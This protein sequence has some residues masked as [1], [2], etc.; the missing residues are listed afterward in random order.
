MKTILNENPFIMY[1]E[2]IATPEECQSI[3]NLAQKSIQPAQ[4]YGHTGERTS[5][6]TWLAHHS[7]SIVH[8][9]SE[10]ISNLIA[11]PLP[12][13]EPLQVASYPVGGKFSAHLD[14]Y[15]THTEYGK[16]K[17]Q[18][19]GQRH[20]TAI[21]YL[22]TVTSGGET[23]FPSL[24]VTISP[25]QGNLL[26]FDNC[27][28]GTNAPNHLSLHEGCPVKEGEKWIATLWFREKLQY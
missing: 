7:D 21:L 5:D 25:I 23:F 1:Q 15:N 24:N 27:T 20:K 10:R 26:L 3:I 6:F 19:G 4:A 2:Q 28:Q 16:N 18:E 9:I 13:A 8:Q 22:N 12:Y 17:V 14:C 11:L